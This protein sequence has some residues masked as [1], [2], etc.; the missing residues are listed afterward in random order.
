VCGGSSRAPL[1][2]GPHFGHASRSTRTSH[3]ADDDA[4]INL[5]TAS[6]EKEVPLLAEKD[7]DSA[8]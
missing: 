5:S 8:G 6:M 1:T 7:T 3:A 4:A 2:V